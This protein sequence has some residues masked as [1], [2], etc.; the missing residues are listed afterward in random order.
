[1][2]KVAK[3]SL[4]VRWAGKKRDR[5]DEILVRELQVVELFRIFVVFKTL[6][7]QGGGGCVDRLHPG[8][9]GGE[10]PDD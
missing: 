3:E 4:L 9:G 1:M 2:S 10:G 8:R 6:F 7:C 5:V